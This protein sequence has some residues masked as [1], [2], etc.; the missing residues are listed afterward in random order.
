M[1]PAQDYEQYARALLAAEVDAY[2]RAIRGPVSKDGFGLDS[3]PAHHAFDLQTAATEHKVLQGGT[4]YRIAVY[5]LV[6]YNAG[7][8]IDVTIK[9]GVGGSVLLGPL[10]TLPA[11]VG[12]ML[13]LADQPYFNMDPGHAFVLSLGACATPR[14][15]G[16]VKY[17]LLDRGPS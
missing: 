11:Q 15:T 16:F 4:G 3:E 13:P 9:D 14:V 6:L 1:N 7:D 10:S 5:M 17:R 2:R 12:L 8:I